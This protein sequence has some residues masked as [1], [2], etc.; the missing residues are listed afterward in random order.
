MYE[1]CWKINLLGMH[2]A[3]LCFA[4]VV[5]PD[6]VRLFQRKL[7]DP[8]NIFYF[9]TPEILLKFIATILIIAG[10]KV[11][12]YYGGNWIGKKYQGLTRTKTSLTED[13]TS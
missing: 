9:L 7:V 4:F 6:D 1:I 13:L 11:K 3:N 12:I 2:G 10:K 5:A 8:A